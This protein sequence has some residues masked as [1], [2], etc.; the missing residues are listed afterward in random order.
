[1][2]SCLYLSLERSQSIDKRCN[3]HIQQTTFWDSKTFHG[4]AFYWR[5]FCIENEST[6]IILSTVE[7]FILKYLNDVEN[8]RN[9]K[10]IREEQINSCVKS[11]DEEFKR[12][13][14][15]RVWYMKPIMCECL[16]EWLLQSHCI[17]Y[18][19]SGAPLA[20]LA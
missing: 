8:D 18:A 7:H 13:S 20:K 17:Y 14:I 19:A 11:V 1:M 16:C 12:V 6:T 3:L 15:L 4:F 9:M 5:E 2:K 10:R